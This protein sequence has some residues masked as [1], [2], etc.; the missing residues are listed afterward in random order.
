MG[1]DPTKKLYQTIGASQGFYK[2]DRINTLATNPFQS[3]KPTTLD[4]RLKSIL[5]TTPKQLRAVEYFT[6]ESKKETQIQSA[7]KESPVIH[8]VEPME[9]VAGNRSTL[10][11][12]G[13]GFGDTLGLV[14]FKN[15]DDGGHTYFEALQTQI[16]RWTNTEIIVEVPTNAGTSPVVVVNGESLY[17]AETPSITITYAYI[18]LLH[19]DTKYQVQ[20]GAYVEYIIHH[21]GGFDPLPE[22]PAGNFSDGTYVFTYNEDFTENALAVSSFESGF[23]QI[24][25]NSGIRFEIDDQT[26]TPN[27]QEADSLNVIS[28]SSLPPGV[29]GQTAIHTL[30]VYLDPTI[31]MKDDEPNDTMYADMFWYT[32]EIDFA[33]S[34]QIDWDFD[35]DGKT[36]STEYDFNAVIRHEIGHAAGLGTSSITKK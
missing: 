1:F 36:E 12:T 13:A 16:V 23:D 31:I 29:L 21:I 3:L 10:T 32:P 17:Y 18:N 6:I 19:S 28:F 22:N 2:Y 7:I 20:N 24:V 26:T 33:F 5:K 34:D 30:A 11:I 14:L 4:N 27:T 35:L 8:T 25:C 9:I 15:A